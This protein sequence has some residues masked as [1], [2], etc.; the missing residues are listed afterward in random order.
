MNLSIKRMGSFIARTSLMLVLLVA[1][2]LLQAPGVQAAGPTC[3]VGASGATYTTIQAAVNDGGC[4][5]IN[6]A[7]GTYTE[8]V[9]IGRSVTINGATSGSTI[10]DGNNAGSVFY[11]TGGTVM[12]DNLTIQH[13][14]GLNRGDGRTFGGGIYNFATLTVSNS[15]ISGNNTNDSGGGIY[16]AGTLTVSNSTISGN[17]TVGV[18]GGI[19]NGSGSTLTVRNSTLSD[20]RANYIG[21]G[22]YNFNNT[23]LTLA[24]TILA[25]S[26]AGRDCVGVNNATNSQNNLIEDGSNACGLVNGVN[27][28]IIGQDPKL[29]PL[30]VNTPGTT[31]T[32][33]L[34]AGSLAI[35]AG[36][37]T[38]CS[39][40]QI[41]NKDQRGFTR[42]TGAHCDIGAYETNATV[43]PM[44][45]V[46][47]TPN[48][49][50]GY[51]TSLLAVGTVTVDSEATITNISC[52]NAT[53]S[54]LTG[55]AHASAT[56]SVNGQ[57][58]TLVTCR[59]TDSAGNS[60][61]ADGSQNSVYVSIDA[62]APETTIT[63]QPAE[64]TAS[65]TA[66]FSFSGVD[67]GNSGV[68]GFQCQLDNGGFAACIS[69]Q[70]YSDL[71]L[72]SHTFQVRAIDNAGNVAASPASFTWTIADSTAPVITPQV[73]GTLGN[74]NWYVSDVTVSWSVVDAESPVSSQSGCE[75]Q[76]IT[77]DTA[78]PSGPPTFTCVATST[79]GTASQSVTLARDTTAPVVTVTGVSNGGN[80]TLGSV[81]VAVCSTTDALSGVATQ[82]TVS[83]TG[84]NADGTGS[85]TATCSG[86]AD[87]AGNQDSATVTY[88][89]KRL[90]TWT[91]FLQPVDNLPT[92][93][94]VNAG[95]A[96]PVKFRLGGDFGLN[97]FASGYPK[98]Q[99]VACPGSSGS[100]SSP[101][102]ETVS[103]DNSSLQ[104]DPTTQTYTYVWKTDKAW[105][106]TCRQLIVRLID[107]TEHI[108]LFQFNGNGRS[109]GASEIDILPLDVTSAVWLT[110]CLVSDIGARQAAARQ[111]LDRREESLQHRGGIDVR[112]GV[113]EA[114]V[115]LREDR[116]AEARAAAAEIDQQQHAV[117]CLRELRREARVD[118]DDRGEAG[119]NQRDR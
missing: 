22:I 8:N 110:P 81:P 84:G 23:T 87:K 85:F 52:E 108:A 69:P 9:T 116:A 93:N 66:S 55:V 118:V 97:I 6:V 41:S 45:T 111:L 109:A 21:G 29:G 2:W 40:A 44:V 36:D 71:S 83:V 18:G 107:G 10:V 101:I 58:G 73:N 39:A 119:R 94:T 117:R 74:N 27:G 63:A 103:A 3:T 33:A 53:V 43:K 28:N 20:N 67:S 11:I 72:G 35:D 100:G 59:A 70:S 30:Q 95:Q 91:G 12:L 32:H 4:A 57:G 14:S 113:A 48:G 80:Y 31:A 75:T 38:V 104:Y 68:A 92:L 47:F 82:A 24:N 115:H 54:N 13:G 112:G 17:S 50:N 16:N 90:Y 76:T 1:G 60:G 102:E 89:V 25:N 34:L 42:P 86:G 61:A 99:T 19:L 46:N 114:R 49:Q 5:T 37:D 51:F 26:P 7:A 105:A 65:T 62:T 96:I 88:T 64:P 98:V 56:V 15:T 106:G 78:A 79:G 77:S